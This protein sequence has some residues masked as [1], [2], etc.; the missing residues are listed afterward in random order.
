MPNAERNSGI[1]P[2]GAQW[3]YTINNYVEDDVLKLRA[4]HTDAKNKVLYHAFQAEVG[5]N[6]TPHLQGYIAF[7]GTKM[8]STV[9]NL[10][11]KRA[12]LERT[13]GT[14]A[15]ASDYCL[16]DAK[17]DPAKMDLFHTAGD[18]AA[19]PDQ[20]LKAVPKS[21]TRTDLNTV[22]RKLDEGA[23]VWELAQGDHFSTTAK[24]WKFFLQYKSARIAPRTEK[25]D[26]FVYYG[27]PGTGKSRAAFNFDKSFAVPASNGTQW[28]DGYDPDKHRV[29][30][31]DD[32]HASVPAHLLLRLCDGYP[33]QFPVKGGFA[34]FRPEAIV[35][36]SNYAPEYWYKWNEIKADLGAFMRRVDEQWFYFLPETEADKKWVEENDCH[37]LVRCQ[38][39][40]WHPQL[41]EF[42]PHP[43]G[44]GL[45]GVPTDAIP[46]TQPLD[47]RHARY[48]TYLRAAHDESVDSSPV[49]SDD[50]DDISDFSDSSSHSLESISSE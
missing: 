30:I 35:L 6:G 4:L 3:C 20:S 5:E 34:E 50:V 28:M 37:C 15:E 8:R 31:F 29:V 44:A 39:G 40:D 19:V 1:N 21:G 10:V 27:A 16:D 2:R 14:P 24:Y 41:E 17:R 23:G 33:L 49:R 48:A 12:H 45:Y 9:A 13:K 22:K 36:T 47:E 46:D 26:V 38:V 18:L 43:A 11:S 25:T 32:F 42:K 7:T